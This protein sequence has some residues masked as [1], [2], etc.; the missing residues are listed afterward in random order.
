MG[1]WWWRWWRWVVVVVVGGE[2]GVGALS[3]PQ[4]KKV[5]RHGWLACSSK[6][7]FSSCPGRRCPPCSRGGRPRSGTLW[8]RGQERTFHARTH[9]S[10]TVIVFA[11][12]QTVASQLHQNKNELGG[13]QGERWPRKSVQIKRMQLLVTESEALLQVKLHIYA[14]V[15]FTARLKM[16]C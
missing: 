6:C 12:V 2:G 1:G 13:Y 11:P 5:L 14:R 10:F 7:S 8:T 16:T 4:Q 9:K 3:A 15:R